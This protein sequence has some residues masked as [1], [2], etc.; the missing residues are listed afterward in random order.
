MRKAKERAPF[1]QRLFDARTKAKLTQEALAKLVGM[2]QSTLGEL[3]YTGQGSSF[4]PQIAAACGVRAEWLA[5][6][7][8]DMVAPVPAPA[9]LFSEPWAE[10]QPVR[11]GK[12][13][14][15]QVVG[16]GSGGDLPERVWTDGDYPVGSTGEYAEIISVDP[17]AFIVRVVGPSMIPKYTPGDYALVEPG[18][19]PD[20][21]DDVLVRLSNGQTMI[22]RL[23][24]RRGDHFRFGSY[25]DPEVLSFEKSAVTWIYYVAYPVPARKIKMRV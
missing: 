18:T 12:Y 2:S 22:K 9:P 23:L 8:G 24:S 25:N 4:T 3:E 7:E 5:T 6:G 20:I 19:D 10:F 17:H 1:G 16:Q 14:F 13:Q 11:P 21:E 15:V